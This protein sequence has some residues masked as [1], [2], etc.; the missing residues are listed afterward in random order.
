MKLSIIV[1]ALGTFVPSH[2][3]IQP[4]S[5]GT[6]VHHSRTSNTITC[7]SSTEVTPETETLQSEFPPILME[8]RDVAMKLH[9]KEQAPREGQAAAPEKPKEPF[10][11]TQADY[12]KFLVDSCQVYKTL[13]EIV[14]RDEL[15]E[16]LGR[17]RNTG[18]ERTNAL[19]QDIQWMCDKLSLERPPVG[20]P[21]QSY[22]D[23]LR[24]M[25]TV[26]EDGTKEGIPEFVC[27]YY[28]FVFAHLAGGRMIGKQMSKMLLDGETLNFYK[29]SSSNCV[30]YLPIFI[31]FFTDLR[32]V[33]VGR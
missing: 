21:G 23:E 22:S 3:F 6:R 32:F 27:H 8:L 18:L 1:L 15:T 29:V 13:E 10:V 20:R 26:K 24:K 33:L 25:I 30:V 2:G 17:F 9:T 5:F 12:L 14:D 28:N 16:E 31:H 4:S 11:P 19:E 7:M